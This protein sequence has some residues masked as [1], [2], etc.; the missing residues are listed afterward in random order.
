L[1][2]QANF[3]SVGESNAV[4]T[5]FENKLL[6]ASGQVS[7]EQVITDLEGMQTSIDTQYRDLNQISDKQVSLVD[8]MPHNFRYVGAI[9]SAF[10]QCKVIQMRRNLGD[11]ALSIYS[12]FF[13]EHHSYA[14]RLAYIAHA[15]YT[16]NKLMDEW[17]D[18]FPEQVIDVYYD[19]LVADPVAQFSKLFS[20]CELNWDEK[21]LQFHHEVVASFTFSE[22]QVRQPINT[23]KLGYWKRYEQQLKPLFDAYQLLGGR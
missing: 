23:N 3:Q 16:A 20:F 18:R 19:E 1:S 9:L 8:K 13:N 4:A 14:C 11:L 21:Y 12:Q 5:L 2:Q 15:I 10:P 17:S 7:P 6:H 22:T